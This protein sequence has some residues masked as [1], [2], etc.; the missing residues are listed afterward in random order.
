MTDKQSIK[1]KIIE[2][3]NDYYARSNFKKTVS[4]DNWI[5]VLEP[6]SEEDAD[7][8]AAEICR[9]YGVPA[10]NNALELAKKGLD[11]V[12]AYFADPTG[13]LLKAKDTG[14]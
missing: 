4:E 2:L 9:E 6:C 13:I 14:Q 10:P 3:T 7:D 11:A 1:A 12:A 5:K 8:A